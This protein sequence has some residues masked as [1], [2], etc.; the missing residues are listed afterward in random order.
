MRAPIEISDSVQK[1]RAV[2]RKLHSSG[3]CGMGPGKSSS[4]ETKELA[5][6]QG[7]W[8]RRAIHFNELA[9]RHSRV[10][11]NPPGKNLFA[12]PLWAAQQHRNVGSGHF[13][14][15]LA[16]LFHGFRTAKQ[17]LFRRQEIGQFGACSLFFLLGRHIPADRSGG[18]Q[19]AH[20][21]PSGNPD[22]TGNVATNKSATASFTMA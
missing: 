12:A 22:K 5:F 17:D 16:H 20:R 14:S 4:F 9:A 6:Q 18:K 7:P 19:K 1:Q 10:L 21:S 15:P 3:F 2:V 13:P 11:V 8:N